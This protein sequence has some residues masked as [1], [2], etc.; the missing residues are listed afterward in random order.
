MNSKDIPLWVTLR[1]SSSLLHRKTNK[2]TRMS[3]QMVRWLWYRRL[4]WFQKLDK[5]DW[6]A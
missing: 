5:N 1:A 4:R 3:A 6:E 2:I